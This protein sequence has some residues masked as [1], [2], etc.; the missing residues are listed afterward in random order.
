MNHSVEMPRNSMSFGQ[1]VVAKMLEL[2]APVARSVAK[3]TATH[4][5]VREDYIAAST[6]I[7]TLDERSAVLRRWCRGLWC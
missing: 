2:S 4:W 7:T 6:T 5:H 3:D 1:I